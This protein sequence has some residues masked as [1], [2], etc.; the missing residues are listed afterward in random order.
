[1]Y[2]GPKI[3]LGS[4]R[5]ADRAQSNG[6]TLRSLTNFNIELEQ[7]DCLLTAVLA[8]ILSIA[9]SNKLGLAEIIYMIF[10][11]D[12]WTPFFLSRSRLDPKH[13]PGTNFLCICGLS[14]TP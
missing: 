11:Y 4:V 14:Y 5:R 3:K 12:L 9:L 6:P 1:M 7:F 8:C 2:K 13:L 10:G